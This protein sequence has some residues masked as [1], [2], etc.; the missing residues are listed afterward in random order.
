MNE[1]KKMVRDHY[2]AFYMMTL[3]AAFLNSAALGEFEADAGKALAFIAEAYG[4]DG[5]ILRAF[6]DLILGDMMKIGLISDYHALSALENLGDEDMEK[7]IF[8]E[9]KGR[10]IEEVN[11]SN[12]RSYCHANARLNQGLKEGMK[13]ESFHH[14]YD[15]VVRFESLKM[16][17]AFGDLGS[18]RQLAILYALG[19]GTEQD[20]E[21][22]GMHLERCV[23]WG[24]VAATLLLK[25]VC[26]RKKDD[27][28]CREFM[29]L[30]QLEKKY[31]EDGIIRL[32]EDEAAAGAVR[33]RYLRIALIRH[34]LVVQGKMEEIDIAFLHAL[35]QPELSAKGKLRLISRY[36]DSQWKD[37]VCGRGEE[38]C[39]GL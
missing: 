27:A 35:S 19:I 31:L 12:R 10:A 9:M 22:A 29:E 6:S 21:K 38:R 5:G 17:A 26:S 37:F 28:G 4:L 11:R 2:E 3:S 7:L 30:Y 24:D 25:E 15:A 23:M 16:Q 39:A 32:P 20:L 18:T 34:Y 13:Y 14:A 36:K 1:I 8:Y 33:E